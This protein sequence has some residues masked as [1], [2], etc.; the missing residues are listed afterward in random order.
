VS[1]GE[2]HGDKSTM[3]VRVTVF[4]IAFFQYSSGFTL[5]HC[6]YGCMFCMLLFDFVNFENYVF[7]FLLY[8]LI[9]MLC[10]FICTLCV[11]C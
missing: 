8:I 6:I 7:L 1:Y 3:Y 2:V 11:L 9:I 10:I 4:L 5:C